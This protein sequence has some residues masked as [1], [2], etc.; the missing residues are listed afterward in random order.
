MQKENDNILIR[1]FQLLDAKEVAQ[2][3]TDAF[4]S[5]ARNLFDKD[6]D[7]LNKM[8]YRSLNT[9]INNGILI[10]E[11]DNII[12]GY[13]KLCS[14]EGNTLKSHVKRIAF[15]K[16]FGLIDSIKFLF[17][18]LMIEVVHVKKDECYISQLAVSINARGKG[19]GSLLINEQE[20]RVR[21]MN[22]IKRYTLH[23]MEENTRAHKLYK[24][25][26]FIEKSRLKF[27]FFKAITGYSSAIYMVKEI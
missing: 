8:F 13:L 18:S 20:K 15:I 22:S 25:L 23:V 12:L 11:Q 5:K 16:E 19:I 7:K 10:A 14:Q 24:K 26:G 6:K 2:I 1:K 27:P 3:K 17:A 4:G 21:K 9:S